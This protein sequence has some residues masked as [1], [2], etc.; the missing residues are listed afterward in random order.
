MTAYRVIDDHKELDN[1]GAVTHSELDA[2]IALTPW[3]IVSGSSG[4][5]PPSARR[6]IAGSGVTIVDTGPGGEMIVSAIPI[7]VS[8][9]SWM[10]RP[11]GQV[12]GANNDFLLAH[13]P[14]PSDALMFYVNGVLQE[15]G[16]DSDYIIVSGSIIHMISSYRSGS[17]VRATYPY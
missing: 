9:V 14:D 10:E 7:P 2:Y 1:A 15:Q 3:L 11:A 6:L 8:L 5:E 4:P 17:N 16:D 12:D 13:D